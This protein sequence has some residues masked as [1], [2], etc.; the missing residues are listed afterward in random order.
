VLARQLDDALDVERYDA[1]GSGQRLSSPSSTTSIA[2]TATTSGRT[3]GAAWTDARD[4]A[5]VEQAASDTRP[6]QAAQTSWSQHTWRLLALGVDGPGGREVNDRT[7]T[8]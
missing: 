1:P 5:H 7:G 6:P 3:A 4:T 2:S 8:R